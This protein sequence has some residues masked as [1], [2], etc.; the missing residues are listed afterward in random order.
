MAASAACRQLVNSFR[1][2]LVAPI[3]GSQHFFRRVAA[4]NIC[5]SFRSTQTY[6]QSV[7]DRSSKTVCTITANA[8]ENFE[9]LSYVDGCQDSCRSA[10]QLA[11]PGVNLVAY[12]CD[13]YVVT[14]P[15]GHRFPM[16]K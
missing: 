6:F 5:Q 3:A 15:D 4:R 11:G 1:L 8:A 16:D 14:L 7:R 12:Y 9:D 2:G 10:T 13:H